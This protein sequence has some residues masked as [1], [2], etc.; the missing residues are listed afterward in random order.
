MSIT[1]DTC[2][3]I[4]LKRKIFSQIFKIPVTELRCLLISF[5]LKLKLD[6][7]DIFQNIV[8]FSNCILSPCTY[9]ICKTCF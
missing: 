3:V 5:L 1:V 9:F 7:Q 4:H 2:K 6:F 8:Y